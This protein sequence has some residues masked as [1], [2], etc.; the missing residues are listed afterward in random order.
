MWR[1]GLMWRCCGTR[2]RTWLLR[3][4]H[5]TLLGML[6][7]HGT[8]LHRMLLRHGPWLYGMLLLDS[9]LLWHGTRLGRILLRRGMLLLLRT[10]LW[11]QARLLWCCMPLL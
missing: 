6:L 7:R 10:L 1:R 8:R 5:R 4:L 2:H 3:V 11:R 9:M